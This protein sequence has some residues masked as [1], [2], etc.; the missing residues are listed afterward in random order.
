MAIQ[1]KKLELLQLKKKSKLSQKPKKEK[2]DQKKVKKWLEKHKKQLFDGVKEKYLQ[3]TKLRL[4]LIR[5]DP[6]IDETKRYHKE[7]KRIQKQEEK[8]KKK[9][10]EMKRKEQLDVMMK[11]RDQENQKRGLRNR[12]KNEDGQEVSVER[13]GESAN[14][15]K[16][17]S[18][19]NK[20]NVKMLEMDDVNT[21]SMNLK[22]EEQLNVPIF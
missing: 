1:N 12:V 3:I 14:L 13:G 4:N 15:E 20:E 21:D 18:V 11:E 19:E 16:K 7:I 5:V 8:R 6:M 22:T 2:Q 17:D 10:T 9:E